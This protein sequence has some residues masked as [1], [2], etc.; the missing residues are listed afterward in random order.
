MNIGALSA[1]ALWHFRTD[2]RVM[3]YAGVGLAVINGEIESEIDTGDEVITQTAELD[4]SATLIFHGG[5]NFKIN[6]RWIFAIDAKAIPYSPTSDIDDDD[7]GV[8][9]ELELNPFILGFGIR[10]RF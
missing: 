7:F 1:S 9:S 5:I 6:E 4:D 10:H 2:A 8:L 3:P